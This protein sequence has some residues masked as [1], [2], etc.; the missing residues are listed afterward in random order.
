M[1]KSCMIAF[2]S[3]KNYICSIKFLFCYMNLDYVNTVRPL[4]SGAFQV[5]QYQGLRSQRD[6]HV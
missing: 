2:F 6:T 5:G 1:K 3:Y 4:T